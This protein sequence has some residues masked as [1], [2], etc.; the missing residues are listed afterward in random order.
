MSPDSDGDGFSDLAEQNL[1][2]NPRAANE[3]PLTFKLSINDDDLVITRINERILQTSISNELAPG[4]FGRSDQ[5]FAAGPRTISLQNPLVP[6]GSPV[7]GPLAQNLILANSSV[8]QTVY[9]STPSQVSSGT[10]AIN[11][12][13]NMQLYGGSCCAPADQ[14]GPLNNSA[15]MY[16]T[17]DN[18]LPTASITSPTAYLQPNDS[19]VVGGTASDPTSYITSVEVSID[20]GAWQPASFAAP[21]STRGST[22]GWAYTY[23]APST[24]GTHL[25][26]SRTTDAV[27]IVSPQSAPMTIHVDS[28]PPTLARNTSTDVNSRAIAG[29]NN[30]WL[31]P[32][33]GT[34][35]DDRAGVDYVDVKLGNYGEFWQR[36]QLDTSV[37]PHRWSMLYTLPLFDADNNM[38]ADPTGLY[39]FVQRA[40]DRSGNQITNSAPSQL[41]IDQTPPSL[42]LDTPAD[43]AEGDTISD[44]ITLG[45]EISESGAVTS[46]VASGEIAFTPQSLVG[47]LGSPLLLLPLETI[48]GADGYEDSSGNGYTALCVNGCPQQLVVGRFGSAVQFDGSASQMLRASDVDV[49]DEQLQPEHLVQDRLRRLRHRLDR[50]G[51]HRRPAD[52]PE[53]RQRLRQRDQRRHRDALLERHRLRRRPVAPRGPGA[54]RRP[55]A[56]C[57]RRAA[58]QRQQGHRQ[59]LARPAMCSW[60]TRHPAAT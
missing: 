25:L 42:T 4:A 41:R 54:Q 16:V 37:T 22:Q 24:D 36:A 10:Y 58:G 53:R 50:Q 2:S 27:G 43:L 39:S 47:V 31:V 38:I 44:Q 56:V 6:L 21:I 30:R 15:A 35:S 55:A 17:V 13:A 49:P 20:G 48:Y 23:S 60:A 1:N 5:I 40:F 45:G 18:D 7:N 51:R 26:R 29:T 52:L 46:G 3:N 28:V 34:V 12:D 59:P 32:L 57:R 33:S 11:I 19:L 14:I 9:F 8:D